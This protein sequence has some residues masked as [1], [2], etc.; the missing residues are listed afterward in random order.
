MKILM[1][2]VAAMALLMAGPALAGD[3]AAGEGKSQVCAACHGVG[4]NSTIP[5]NPKL[6][7]QYASYLEFALQSYR[8]GSRKNPIMGAQVAALSD[9]DIADL[10]AYFAAQPALLAV[11]PKAP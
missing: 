10:A 8:D 1:N 11:V 2:A 5:M 6:A 4:G 7:G 9:E 3:A